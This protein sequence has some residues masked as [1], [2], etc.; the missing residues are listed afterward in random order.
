MQPIQSVKGMNDIL[1]EE[2]ALW[3]FAEEKAREI[4]QRFGYSEIR[5]PIVE[6]T[7][8][9][10]R[11]I[12][13]ATDIVEKEM[14]TFQDKKGRSLTLRPEATAS[15]IRA[16]IQ[17]QMH[18]KSHQKK[19]YLIGPMF[20]HERPQKGRYRQFHQINVEVF[21][22]D[23]PMLD[24]EVMFL[25]C[26]FLRE[27]GLKEVSL[28]INSLGCPNCRISFREILQEYLLQYQESLCPDCNRRVYKNPLRCFDCKAP[29]CKEIL[30][31]APLI[32]DFICDSCNRHFQEVQN[33]LRELNVE[34]IINGRMVRGLDYYVKT[35]FEIVTEHL[36]AQNAVG[37]GGRYDGLMKDLGGPDL[38]GIGFAL[39]MERIILLLKDSAKLQQD[40]NQMIYCVL[41]GDRARAEGF[42][43][44]QKLRSEGFIV[45]LS[46]EDRSAKS[47]MRM[48]NK[49]GARMAIIIGDDELSQG[50]VQLRDMHRSS[51]WVVE[52]EELV[53]ELR[54][55]L[56]E[57]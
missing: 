6:K 44:A 21:G 51:Q 24:A 41:L 50:V 38:P 29:Q 8:L 56:N 11:G 39:G 54:S 7:E 34:F 30:S 53:P 40:N 42:K 1:P 31:N 26:L 20:R 15:I 22:I 5:T 46:Y 3:R 12:G 13:E 2:I 28:E 37:G 23:E 18:V 55:I 14:Y 10:T 43:L 48:A 45:D 57:S 27:I 19:F 52:I 16:Y 4:F 36:G 32:L 35:A 49:M 47:Q 9:F 33:F 17:H 25:A